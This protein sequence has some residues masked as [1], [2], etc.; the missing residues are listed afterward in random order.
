MS[1]SAHRAVSIASGP[2][3]LSSSI[4]PNHITVCFGLS[5]DTVLTTTSFLFYP[6]I[7]SPFGSNFKICVLQDRNLCCFYVSSK[8]LIRCSATPSLAVMMGILFVS[9]ASGSRLSD[10]SK[11]SEGK[12]FYGRG[13]VPMNVGK[14]GTLH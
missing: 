8:A 1:F 5:D 7:H 11:D 14:P 10:G 9:W 2:F 3:F 13:R 4:L 12:A 6:S